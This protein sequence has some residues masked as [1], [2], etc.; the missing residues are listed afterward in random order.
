[1]FVN[2]GARICKAM[3]LANELANSCQTESILT[4]MCFLKE[5]GCVYDLSH[6]L[7]RYGLSDVWTCMCFFR[8][9]LLAKRLSQPSNSHRNGFSPERKRSFLKYRFVWIQVLQPWI[10]LWHAESMNVTSTTTLWKS[11]LTLMPK[12]EWWRSRH[13]THVASA[14]KFTKTSALYDKISLQDFW[15]LTAADSRM[16]NKPCFGNLS[17]RSITPFTLAY[18]AIKPT[19]MSCN[20]FKHCSI[21]SKGIF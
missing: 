10:K 2:S 21:I 11:R 19:E 9:L 4:F 13:H 15:C 6:S 3:D 16:H 20:H 18:S 5:L 1:M 14:F 12:K 17:L 7:H 8:S